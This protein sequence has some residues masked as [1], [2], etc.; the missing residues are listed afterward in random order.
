[1][2][3]ADVTVIAY[4]HREHGEWIC[5]V[6]VGC[7]LAC[8]G[9]L[10]TIIANQNLRPAEV[11]DGVTISLVDSLETISLLKME[12]PP[13]L[14]EAVRRLTKHPLELELVTPPV[15]IGDMFVWETPTTERA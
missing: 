4:R 11:L 7:E 10:S 14:K 6:I 9:S 1:M 13:A 15:D 2:T 12:G 8:S 5:Q 3:V